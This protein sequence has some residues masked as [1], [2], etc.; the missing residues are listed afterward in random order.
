MLYYT[1]TDQIAIFCSIFPSNLVSS[2]DNLL[3]FVGV[4]VVELYSTV[5][6]S[7][8]IGSQLK[9]FVLVIITVFVVV[10]FLLI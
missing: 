4:E 10:A 6:L 3:Y 1:D 2:V 5:W 8:L 7:W 9:Y